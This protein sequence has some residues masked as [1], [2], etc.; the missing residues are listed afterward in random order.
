MHKQKNDNFRLNKMMIYGPSRIFCSANLHTGWHNECDVSRKT[1]L[2]AF[3]PKGVPCG[4]FSVYSRSS[5][6]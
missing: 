6:L 1:L 4:V 5:F 2:L 3:A